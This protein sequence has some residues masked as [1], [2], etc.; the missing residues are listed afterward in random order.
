MASG[1]LYKNN[2]KPFK[3]QF[4]D[5]FISRLFSYCIIKLKCKLI[6]ET[7]IGNPLVR[8]LKAVPP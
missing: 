4:D 2:L 8:L 7:S 3:V 6:F 5:V 1:F